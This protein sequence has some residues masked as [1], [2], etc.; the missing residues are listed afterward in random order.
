LRFFSWLITL[1]LAVAAVLF[2]VGNR[3]P[4]VLS[5]WPFELEL[6]LPV[7]LAVLGPLAVGVLLGAVAAWLGALRARWLA[8]R[9]GTRIAQ[10]TAELDALKQQTA[11]PAGA[12]AA[13]KSV[14]TG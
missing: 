14:T 12:A 10:L 13:P 6:E 5:L 8:R 3:G 11:T 2:A 7:Y 1:P 4:V 9:R